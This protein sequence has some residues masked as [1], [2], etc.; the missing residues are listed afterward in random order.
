[1]KTST[2]LLIR[3]AALLVIAGSLFAYVGDPVSALA[4]HIGEFALVAWIPVLLAGAIL[5]LLGK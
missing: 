5:R 1:M 2:V 3:G 4:I